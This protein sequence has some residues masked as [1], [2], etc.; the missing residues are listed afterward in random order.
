MQRLRRPGRDFWLVLKLEAL[1]FIRETSTEDK[2]YR[3]TEVT[4]IENMAQHKYES[5]EKWRIK[6]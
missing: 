6:P 3:V 2:H 1:E 5:K 4:R